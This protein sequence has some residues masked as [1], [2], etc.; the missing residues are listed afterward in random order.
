MGYCDFE[1]YCETYLSAAR[2]RIPA[3]LDKASYKD[4]LEEVL[5]GSLKGSHAAFC[6]SFATGEAKPDMREHAVANI[7]KIKAMREDGWGDNRYLPT[8]DT[9]RYLEGLVSALLEKRDAGEIEE[10]Y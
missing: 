7:E 6:R 4:N 3:F 2:K 8:E 10:E 9:D 1:N 5:V